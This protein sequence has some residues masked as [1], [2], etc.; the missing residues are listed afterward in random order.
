MSSRH[1]RAIHFDSVCARTATKTKTAGRAAAFQRAVGAGAKPVLPVSDCFW[2]DGY[3]WVADPFGYIWALGTVKEVA[4]PRTGQ[5]ANDAAHD[6]HAERGRKD[7][8]RV[9]VF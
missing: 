5:P 2:D 4:H 7:Q 9:A 3:G 8:L 6:A 1:R